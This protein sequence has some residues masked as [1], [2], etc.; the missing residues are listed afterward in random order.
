MATIVQRP[1]KN[2]QTSYRVQ[3]R[4]KGSPPQSASFRPLL[5][6]G[7]GQKSV[8]VQLLKVGT[9]HQQRQNVTR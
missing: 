5:R 3:V 2:G 6:L 8:R 4:R 9:S 1:G 7:N